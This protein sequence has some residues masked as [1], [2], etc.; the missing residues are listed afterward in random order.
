M[1][2]THTMSIIYRDILHPGSPTDIN[3]RVTKFII[4]FKIQGLQSR[5]IKATISVVNPVFHQSPFTQ[6]RTEVQ[7]GMFSFDIAF[8]WFF[9]LSKAVDT[10]SDKSG[11]Y[12]QHSTLIIA[13]VPPWAAVSMPKAILLWITAFFIGICSSFKAWMAFVLSRRACFVKLV[14]AST[15]IVISVVPIKG[16][17]KAAIYSYHWN[18]DL[19]HLACK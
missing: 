9:M 13:Q 5:T 6:D 1:L 7:K 15:L 8:T 2:L 14:K 16:T 11:M 10:L 19:V 3:L 4:H 12:T 18:T 17:N